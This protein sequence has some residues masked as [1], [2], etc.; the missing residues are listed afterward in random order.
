MSLRSTFVAVWRFSFP[1]ALSTAPTAISLKVCKKL[2]GTLD[3]SELVEGLVM[4]QKVSRGAGGPGRIANAKIGLIQFCLSPPKT[5]MEQNVVIKDYSQMDRLLRE[6]RLILARMVKQV[7]KTG[8]N[9]LLIQKSILRDAT[10]ELSLDF[11][12]KAKI[13]VIK[14]VER[15]DIEF[16]SKTLG[17]EPAATIDTFTADKLGSAGLVYE[18]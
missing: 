16:I 7:A 17:V 5:D 10:T 15:D 6:E 12:A 2:G 9:V 4:T 11:C 3:D 18:D 13:M 1:I 8:C 14:D